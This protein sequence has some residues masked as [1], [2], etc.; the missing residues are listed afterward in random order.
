[1]PYPAPPPPPPPLSPPSS[2]KTTRA[3]GG[4]P[5]PVATQMGVGHLGG[6]HLGGASVQSRS[7]DKFA[8]GAQPMLGVGNSSTL[9]AQHH[10]QH[11]PHAHAA[12]HAPQH[13]HAHGGHHQA[14][15]A[16]EMTGGKP[17]GKKSYMSPYSQRFQQKGK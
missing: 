16:P 6:A 10:A 2:S 1:M 9:A 7:L 11:H 12:H 17:V 13:A 3:E 4:T 15:D 14:L 8:S 5:V